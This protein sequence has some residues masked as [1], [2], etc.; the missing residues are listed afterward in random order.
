MFRRD[1][2][3]IREIERINRQHAQERLE[4]LQTISR[5]VGKPDPSEPLFVADEPDPEDDIEFDPAH[6]EWMRA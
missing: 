1:R 4:L 2:W 3:W 6:P 5:M